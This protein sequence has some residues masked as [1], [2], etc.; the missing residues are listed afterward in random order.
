MSDLIAAHEWRRA[1]DKL[2]QKERQIAQLA[3]RHARGE[4][5]ADDI[6]ALMTEVSVLRKLTEVLFDLA[7]R[8]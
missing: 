2:L 3:V 4:I 6:Q 8:A 7:F 1:H 5:S